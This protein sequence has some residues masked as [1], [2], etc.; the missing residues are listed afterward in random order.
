LN[1]TRRRRE[2]YP[3]RLPCQFAV[4]RLVAR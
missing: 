3:A 1:Y 4:A 2:S